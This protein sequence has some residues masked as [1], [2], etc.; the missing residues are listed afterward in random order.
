MPFLDRAEAGRRLAARLLYLRGE[1]VVVL[2]LA[3]GGVPVAAEVAGALGADLDVVLVRKLGLPT[4][5]ELA[6]GA[7]AEGGIRLLN[8]RVI[9][10]WDVTPAE[11]VEVERTQQA[12][13]A[14][15]AG[16]FRRGRPARPVAGRT[17]LVVDD[18]MAPGST[19][20]AAGRAARAMGAE[21][22]IL[23]VPVASPEAVS[24]LG[25][26]ME[27]VCVEVPHA[28]CA[29]GQ[30][31][32]EFPQTSDDEVV[33]L[34]EEVR[35]SGPADAGDGEAVH[36]PEGAGAGDHGQHLAGGDA[37]GGEGDG[38]LPWGAGPTG[39]QAAVGADR[40]AR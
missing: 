4:Q 40:L 11:L 21:R 26:E 31:Y 20:R 13:L 14:R 36:P 18:G 7:I 32:K 6:M 34:L 2:G 10:L 27:V 22:V 12:E 30:W 23:A 37:R 9:R 33:R 35:R 16:R 39:G 29:V 38:H 24:D 25:R 1:D 8:P 28:M 17:A 5:P 3:R 19:A 15:Q